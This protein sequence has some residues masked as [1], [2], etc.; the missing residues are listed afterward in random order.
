MLARKEMLT[1]FNKNKQHQE[2]DRVGILLSKEGFPKER[3]VA[4]SLSNLFL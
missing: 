3:G 2:K 4:I 1:W